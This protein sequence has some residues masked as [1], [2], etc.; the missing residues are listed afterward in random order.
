[1]T[2]AFKEGIQLFNSQKFFE[3]HEVLET[4]WLK[5]Q[6]DEKVFLQGIIQVA[7]AFHHFSRG[8]PAGTQ[9]LLEEGCNKLGRFGDTRSGLDLAGLLAQIGLWQNSLGDR[10][11]AGTPGPRQPSLP[12]IE[13][14]DGR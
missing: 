3:C 9:S 4:L 13:Y 11:A 6:G 8:N 14:I 1:M 5:A 12:R 10:G 7:A 2:D